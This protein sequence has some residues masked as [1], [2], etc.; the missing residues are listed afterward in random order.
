MPFVQCARGVAASLCILSATKPAAAE[1]SFN[2]R[3]TMMPDL[4][5]HDIAFGP[6]IAYWHGLKSGYAPTVD[7]AYTQSL[8][9]VSLNLGYFQ[10]P[11]RTLYAARSEFSIWFLANWGAGIGYV[12]G[13]DHGPTAHL[14]TGFPFGAEHYFIEPYYRANIMFLSEFDVGH[15]LGLMAKYTTHNF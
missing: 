1:C 2:N 4:P 9:A 8:F 15:E 14:F 7:V 5:C 13:D 6:G 12:A 3:R 10:E 11:N